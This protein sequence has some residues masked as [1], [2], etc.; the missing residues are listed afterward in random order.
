[1]TRNKLK[2][3]LPRAARKTGNAKLMVI[4]RQKEKIECKK[5]TLKYVVFLLAEA[6]LDVEG[7]CISRLK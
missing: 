5:S 1:V 3:H 7:G 4:S 2:K 6:R